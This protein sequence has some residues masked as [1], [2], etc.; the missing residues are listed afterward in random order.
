MGLRSGKNHI[1]SEMKKDRFHQKRKLTTPFYISCIV[2]KCFIISIGSFSPNNSCSWLL[3][4]LSDNM[5]HEAS[6]IMGLSAF[7]VALAFVLGGVDW[8]SSEDRRVL[9]LE[10]CVIVL[11]IETSCT[12]WHLE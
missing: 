12:S 3:G 9:S 7:D 1:L 5:A 10:S 2:F 4:A 11:D 8:V 6:E